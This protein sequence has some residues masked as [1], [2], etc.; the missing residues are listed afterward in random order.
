M[1]NQNSN[2]TGRAS[3]PW[4]DGEIAYLKSC[5]YFH[6]N[7]HQDLISS[8][9]LHPKATSHP[10]IILKAGAGRAI[11]TT[12][13]A[14]NSGPQN[15]FL[16]P[17]RM[18]AHRGKRLDDFHAFIGTELPPNSPNAHLKLSD[19]GAKMN[20]PK[21]SWVYIQQ[22][23]TVPYTVLLRWDKVPQRLRVSQKSLAQLR[24][25]IERK[26]SF[27]LQIARSRLTASSMAAEPTPRRVVSEA[28]Q[29][30]QCPRAQQPRPS[31]NQHQ[32]RVLPMASASAPTTEPPA[33]SPQRLSYTK[34]TAQQDITKTSCRQAASTTGVSIH[35]W[36]QP[37]KT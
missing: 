28:R 27:Q 22:F 20:K 23:F 16:P 1:N 14:F 17:W 30:P 7:D 19:S 31:P 12:V 11:V 18:L 35:S 2:P 6:P 26:Y 15:N 32:Q 21:A 36:R 10:V 24:A 4:H 34:V 25:D 8:G 3:H 9:Y 5:E 33:R 13:T 29:A 37:I